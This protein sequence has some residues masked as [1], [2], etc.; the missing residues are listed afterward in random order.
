MFYCIFGLHQKICACID[1]FTAG[2]DGLCKPNNY[3]CPAGKPIQSKGSV[4]PCEVDFNDTTG[5]IQDNCGT[6]SFCFVPPH[7]LTNLGKP[8]GHCCP[9][10]AS[11]DSAQLV[12]PYG[13]PLPNV[14]CPDRKANTKKEVPNTCPLFSHQCFAVQQRPHDMICC[15]NPCRQSVSHFDYNGQC[16]D[17]VLLGRSC[18]LHAQCTGEAECADSSGNKICKCKKGYTQVSANQCEES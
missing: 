7:T 12:C 5:T 18:T 17:Y 2:D 8:I 13:D 3:L 15:P 14:T 10:P 11:A 16:F 1:G 9:T 4:V 6:G